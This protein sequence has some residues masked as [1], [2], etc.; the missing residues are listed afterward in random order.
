MNSSKRTCIQEKFKLKI[1]QEP[2]QNDKGL[3]KHNQK[4]GKAKRPANGI[5]SNAASKKLSN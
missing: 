3:N 1:V 5:Y 4:K 2:I